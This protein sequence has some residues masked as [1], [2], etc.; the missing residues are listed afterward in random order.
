MRQLKYTAKNDLRNKIFVM[1]ISGYY[2]TYF[3]KWA[4]IKMK[5]PKILQVY[6]RNEI[7]KKKE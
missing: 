7:K 1:N 4:L 3:K 5:H 6:R 2:R